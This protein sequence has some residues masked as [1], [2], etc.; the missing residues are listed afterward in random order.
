MAIGRIIRNT[1]GFERVTLTDEEEQEVLEKLR[2]RNLQIY[3]RCLDDAK[4][5]VIKV[6]IAVS[7]HETGAAGLPRASGSPRAPRGA[8]SL[9]SGPAE[10]NPAPS[11]A[12][13]ISP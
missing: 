3:E 4:G 1:N 9:P 12:D 7:I 11:S 2:E 6:R 5:M 10:R 13:L 8:L